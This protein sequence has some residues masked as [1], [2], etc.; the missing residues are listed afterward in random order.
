MSDIKFEDMVKALAKDGQEVINGLT[1]ESAHI[2]HMVVGVNTEIGELI[3]NNLFLGSRENRV[4]ELGDIEF[5]FE[6]IAAPISAAHYLMS[7]HDKVMLDTDTAGKYGYMLLKLA[8]HGS[9]LLDAAK[10]YSIYEKPLDL[11][12]TIKQ[13]ISIRVWLCAIYDELDIT[14]DEAIEANI[15]KLGKRYSSGSY[16]NNQAQT[17]ADKIQSRVFI[18]GEQRCGKTHHSKALAEFFG[19]NTIMDNNDKI[20]L[21]VGSLIL[22]T[23]I[24]D[25][26]GEHDQVY[27]FEN[28]MQMAGIKSTLHNN[29]E[30]F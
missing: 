18:Y 20:F 4:E 6:G 22:C 17:R 12:E 25:C 9:Q 8:M 26:V 24:P 15:A 19:C 21:P 10:K 3:E 11:K 30:H 1:P 5:Y 23:E 13:L 27:S 29:E 14:R 7:D 16:S 2:L 28:A